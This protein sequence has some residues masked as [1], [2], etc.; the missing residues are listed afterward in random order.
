MEE[1]RR[2]S[3]PVIPVGAAQACVL[4]GKFDVRIQAMRIR[5]LARLFVVFSVVLSASVINAQA[6]GGLTVDQANDSLTTDGRQSYAL[7]YDGASTDQPGA[8]NLSIDLGDGFQ[9]GKICVGDWAAYDGDVNVSIQYH[10]DDGEELSYTGSYAENSIL[11]VSSVLQGTVDQ[12]TITTGKEDLVETGFSGV[13]V[14]GH[15][16]ADKAGDTLKT[17]CTYSWKGADGAEMELAKES[18]TM[19]CGKY[20][21]GEP[22]ITA[23]ASNIGYLGEL[24]LNVSGISGKGNVQPKSYHVT[25]NLS[26]RLF[27][28]GII[29][30]EFDHAT[31]KLYVDGREQDI[32]NARIYINTKADKVELEIIPDIGSFKQTKDMVIETRNSMNADGDETYT[33]SVMAK[34]GNASVSEKSAKIGSVHFVAESIPTEPEDP[35]GPIE[36]VDPEQPSDPSGPSEPGK[37][38][39]GSGQSGE[40]KP[41]GGETADKPDTPSIIDN[42]NLVGMRL[43]NELGNDIGLDVVR[44]D[45][46]NTESLH[47]ALNDRLQTTSVY[48]FTAR[49]DDPSLLDGGSES[50]EGLDGSIESWTDSPNDTPAEKIEKSK[51]EKAKEKLE[52]IASNSFVWILLILAIVIVVG[53]IVIT[54]LF[55]GKE[56]V[57]EEE[58]EDDLEDLCEEYEDDPAPDSS[59]EE[60]K[61][62]DG[63]T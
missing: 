45:S 28:D 14:D 54:I 52:E 6:A 35:S 62:P 10:N 17:I 1:R 50:E 55:K 32:K 38:P 9:A 42:L 20:E 5:R 19:D 12:I 22:D 56:K 48:D 29:L 25:V 43:E 36:P 44:S 27:V 53:A 3:N 51:P 46:A 60:A 4:T 15:V 21:V 33:V 13:K 49:A 61:P 16:N 18:V 58:M 34:Y 26:K 40:Q 39:G 30:P 8:G 37:N 11:N 31:Y 2:T 24:D 63:E 7:S 41:G 59:L 23:S 57:I 47:N